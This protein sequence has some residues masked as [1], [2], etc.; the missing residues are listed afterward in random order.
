[1]RILICLVV[2]TAT[3]SAGS[4]WAVPKSIIDLGSPDTATL[5][6]H[7]QVADG[8]TT[9]ATIGG[10]TCR[11]NVN[12]SEDRYF[13]FGIDNSFAYQGSR[14]TLYITIHYYDTGSGSLE[15]HYDSTSAAYTSGG[16]VTLTNS[17]TWK[18]KGFRVT[19]GYF[20]NRQNGGADFRIVGPASTTFYLDLVYAR[21]FCGPNPRVRIH[22]PPGRPTMNAQATR[23]LMENW[24]QWQ[25]TRAYTNVFGDYDHSIPNFTDAELSSF[26]AQL[27]AS[28]IGICMETGAITQN[29]G[30]EAFNNNKALHDRIISN[31]GPL[32]SLAMQEPLTGARYNNW[33]NE[34]AA[35]ETVD[36]I[37]LV[38]QN[39]PGVRIGSIEAY[40][41]NSQ[42]LL[43]W[44]ITA[45]QD[46]CAQ[47]G[48]EGIDFFEID[49]DWRIFPSQGNWTTVKNLETWCH[50]NGLAYSVIYWPGPHASSM[51][52]ID[53]YT[54]IM[55]QG[56]AYKNAGGAPDEYDIQCWDYIPLNT[57]PETTNYTFTN[58]AIRFINAYVPRPQSPYNGVISLPGIIRAENFDKGGENVAYHDLSIGNTG[59]DY[60]IDDSVDIETVGGIRNV[61]WI[62]TAEWLE[63]TVNVAAVGSYTIEVRVATPNNGCTFHIEING[64]NVT[65]TQTIPNTTD[66]RIWTSKIVSGVS[67][68]AGEQTLR[69]VVDSGSWNVDY[70]YVRSAAA[71]IDPVT[72]FTADYGG[73]QNTLSWTNS[74]DSRFTGTMIRYK[75]TGYP[76]SVTDGT[77]VINKS[78]NPGTSDSHIHTGLTSTVAY[79]YSAF[80]HDGAG[81]YASKVDAGAMHPV[82]SFTASAGL[83]QV[84]LSWQNPP[85][86]DYTGTM[87]R[88]K[89]NGYP[90]DI[91][92]GALLTD[93]PGPPNASDGCV[94]SGLIT[95]A[96]CYYR[97]FS[98]DALNNYNTSTSV[99]AS[100]TTESATLWLEETFD[101]RA[102]GNLGGQG[103]WTTVAA[104]S[105][106]ESSFASGGSG[107]A[108]LLDC[109]AAGGT[110]TN[111]YDGF[112]K[113]TSGVRAVSFDVSQ[114]WAGTTSTTIFGS[115]YFYGD[116]SST[117]IARFGGTTGQWRLEY[118][119]GNVAILESSVVQNTWYNVKLVFDVVTRKVSVYVNGAS[120]GSNL[121][122]KTGSGTNIHRISP[123]SS[124]VS[125]LTVQQLY[126][127]NIRGETSPAAPASVTDDGAY[128]GSLSKLHCSWTSGGPSAVEHKYGIGTFAGS[129]NVLGW[130]DLGSALEVTKDGLS[131]EANRTYYFTVQ[132]GNGYGTWSNSTNSNGIKTPT[133]AVD[134]LAAKGLPNG[135]LAADNRAIRGKVISAAFPGYFYIQEPGGYYG[136]KAL[137]SAAVTPGAY[138][139]VAG[140]MKGAGAE[141]YIDCTGNAI[142]TTTPGPGV[143]SPVVMT[144][145]SVGGASL[146]LY[147]PGVTG[148]IGPHNIGSP[149]TIY[150][151][152]TQRK[153]TDPKYFYVD[154]GCGLRDGTTTGGEENVGIRVMADPAA[155]AEGCYVAI[156]GI[157][158][159]FDSA[160]MRPE[161]LPIAITVLRTP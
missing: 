2:L 48:V 9:P 147:S 46:R 18:S 145:A 146:G 104:Q 75:T 57:V 92:D 128:T 58:G 60:R 136:L 159:C 97:A 31:G 150:G 45:L 14:P 8:D 108:I 54:D 107:K 61:G 148:A 103:N 96:T 121:A 42:S 66:W 77:L 118:G 134:I 76:T 130:T 32:D 50:N 161:I 112:A 125:G 137:S 72:N 5:M 36:W 41:Y 156:A 70:V 74:S 22:P 129:T 44:W 63:Y 89:T 138:V 16:A 144:N 157:S 115:L 160:G 53:F 40:P 119:S 114:T 34:F 133:A 94:H 35:N 78:N 71:P 26:Y 100:G 111:D 117:E 25:V 153:T 132:S 139:D 27:V 13:Y 120:K 28:G 102:N 101:A 106:V 86:L 17:N 87:V 49:C 154:D 73:S 84:N 69:L 62:E 83:Q 64:T 158:S 59:G 65:G 116:D 135:S 90:S 91:S 109:V 30:E 24:D 23:D 21:D 155:Y 152:V 20:G 43:Q 95:G 140:L 151:R 85:N 124:I 15:L 93:E 126:L 81:G 98:H 141:R 10:L 3:L 12:P 52:D 127:D 99:T 7:I 56:N 142:G 37:Q 113:K 105:Q 79:Y 29:G 33:G 82:T 47:R 39:R 123:S 38:R 11:R 1:M 6:T 88:Y 67:L 55:N 80:A 68:N 131:L 51:N 110:V 4:L 143:P 122:W 19:D 149:V